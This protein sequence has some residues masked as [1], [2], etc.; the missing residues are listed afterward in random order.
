MEIYDSPMGTKKN[1]KKL[2][3]LP[4]EM[5]FG[6][7]KSILFFLGYEINRT[8]GSHFIFTKAGFDAIII[9]VHHN[10]VKRVYLLDIKRELANQKFIP[11]L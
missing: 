5:R 2:M 1:I 7:I 8:R 4:A 9:P 11:P 10:K 6:E 3:K